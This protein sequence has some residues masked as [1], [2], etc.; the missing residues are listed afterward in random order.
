[1]GDILYLTKAKYLQN[2]QIEIEFSSGDKRLVDLKN[3]LDKPVFLPLKDLEF[4][5]QVKLNPDTDT[6]EWPNT[7]D[8]APE[9]LLKIGKPIN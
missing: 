6:I 2:Y 1:M 8:F 9:F 5:K 3:H 4:F 7:A